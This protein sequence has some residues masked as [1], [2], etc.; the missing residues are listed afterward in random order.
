[1][2][3]WEARNGQKYVFTLYFL[4]SKRRRSGQLNK[5]GRLNGIKDYQNWSLGRPGCDLL[6][7]G[8]IWASLFFF[9]DIL[10]GWQKN[11]SKKQQN[12]IGANSNHNPDWTT[13]LRFKLFQLTLDSFV[14]QRLTPAGVGRFWRQLDFEGVPNRSSSNKINR[15]LQQRVSRQATLTKIWFWDWFLM[16]ELKVL[17]CNSKHFALYLLKNKRFRCF[18]KRYRKW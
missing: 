13:K 1:M 12:P 7:F 5:N 15:K 2:L 17:R 9:W 14:W 6:R 3:N 4:Q 11:I 18:A 10:G 8:W 16:P